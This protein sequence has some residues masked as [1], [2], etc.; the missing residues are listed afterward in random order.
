MR[1]PEQSS[2]ILFVAV[3]LAAFVACAVA[4]Q[5]WSE[6]TIRLV[7]RAS[8]RSSIVLFSLA[9][10]ASGLQTLFP[11]RA[12][13]YLLRNRRYVGLSFALSHSVHLAALVT[14]GVAFPAPFVD[15]LDSLTLIGGGIAYVF[16]YAM[17]ITSSDAAVRMLGGARWRLLHR[18]GSWYIWAIFVQTYLPLAVQGA[19]FL[20]PVALTLL[21]ALL[22]FARSRRERRATSR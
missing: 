6:E 10:S 18:V 3:V 15:E 12:S 5:G 20:A 1:L 14:L 7:V 11:S 21:A 16:I 19:G 4:L 17:A 22:R 2:I 13:A 9:F 8:A